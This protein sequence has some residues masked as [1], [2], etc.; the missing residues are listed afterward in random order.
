MRSALGMIGAIGA[1]G[2]TSHQRARATIFLST[3]QAEHENVGEYVQ[4]LRS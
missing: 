2:M 4:N 3:M 1:A